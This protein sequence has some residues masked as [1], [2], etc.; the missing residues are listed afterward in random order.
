M[1]P[2]QD[3]VNPPPFLWE[4]SQNVYVFQ[5]RHPFSYLKYKIHTLEKSII[6]KL[7]LNSTQLN[8]IQTQAEC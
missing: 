4:F 3:W 2:V 1:Q 8:S 5:W 6:A 7:S